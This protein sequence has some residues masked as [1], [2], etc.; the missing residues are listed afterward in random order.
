MVARN[1]GL[2]YLSATREALELMEILAK[3]MASEDVWD[4]SAYN[5][6][7]FR[8]AYGGFESAG[9][10]VRS[11][12]YLCFCNT[13]FVFKVMRYD[14]QLAAPAVHRPVTVHIN[15]H[16]EKEARMASVNKYYHGGQ[17]AA[18]DV[19]NGGEGQR[20]G[21]CRGK[22]GVM[23][24]SFS[25]V[26]SAELR[27]HKLAGNVIKADEEWE[28]MGRGPVRFLASG[29]LSTPWG[30][31]TWGTVPSPWRKDTLHV[32]LLDEYYLLMFLSEKWSF[33]ALRCTDEQVTYGALKRT[34]VPSGRLVF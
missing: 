13:K 27:S 15:Y 17:A 6:E 19:W 28:W 16:P 31:G 33:V 21:T 4:Q 12:N 5:M 23:K 24:E 11:M 2:F 32:R 9:V 8:P 3:R 14:A 26:T 1:S 22:V 25:T 34:D 20:T 30:E 18:L 10:S 29:E 7:I